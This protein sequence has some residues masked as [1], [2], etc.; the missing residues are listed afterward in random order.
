MR[1]LRPLWRRQL[2]TYEYTRPQ[3]VVFGLVDFERLF[4][5]LLPIAFSNWARWGASLIVLA[6]IGGRLL[7]C[8]FLRWW[9]L[10]LPS[11]LVLH[12]R[13]PTASVVVAIGRSSMLSH[14]PCGSVDPVLGS[15]WRLCVLTPRYLS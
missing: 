7:V 13:W 9:V 14:S 4:E 3:V 12:G 15:I 10:W 6:I 2:S 1:C 11:L 5:C 8:A